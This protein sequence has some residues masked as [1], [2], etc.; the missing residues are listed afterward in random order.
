MSFPSVSVIKNLPA[1]A[2]DVGA[3]PGLGR[4]PGEGNGSLLQYSCRENPMDR[5]AWRTAVHKAAKSQT[6]LS[7]WALHAQSCTKRW[8]SSREYEWGMHVRGTP[9]KRHLP[10]ILAK[11]QE[12]QYPLLGRLESTD[13]LDL[14]WVTSWWTHHKLKIPNP[15]NT[16]E[17]GL[18]KMGAQ[19]TVLIALMLAY[20]W[21]K[22][23]DVRHVMM[24]CC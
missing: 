16:V 24:K 18:P 19:S 11:L 8:R 5:G 17:P 12:S 7:N 14:R 4:S 22:S 2:G 13:L 10:F 3:I 21:A 15:P 23:S 9:R 6:R 20:S 1:N